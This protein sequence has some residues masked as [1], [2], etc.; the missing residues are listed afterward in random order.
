M[1]FFTEIINGRLFSP[2]KK[3]IVFGNGGHARTIHG[4]FFDE[5]VI[6]GFVVDDPFVDDQP[7]IGSTTVYPL[8]KINDHFPPDEYSILVALGFRDLN[9]FR[10]RKSIE[11]RGL[12]YD[13]VGFI[14]KSVRT[15]G[16]FNVQ[17]NTIILGNSD[18]H[19]GVNIGEG[20]FISSGAVLGHDSVLGDYSWVGS[21]TILAGSVQIGVCSVLGMNVSV[22][23]NA[24]LAHHT[25]V[26]P[27]TFVNM[28]TD[29]YC[30]VVSTSGKIIQVDSRKLHRFSYK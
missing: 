13:F 6:K 28:N 27:N 15:P 7:I 8:S 12:G 3:L 2:T 20:V 21:G 9:E 29:P 14:D 23:Q 1:P 26:S 22:K 10:M 19:D 30:S 18:I 4:Y 11:L 5:E 17:S 16:R 25:L 24:S